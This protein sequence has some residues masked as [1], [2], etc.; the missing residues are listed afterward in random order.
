MTDQD[1]INEIQEN[2]AEWLEMSD[3]PSDHLARILAKRLVEQNKYIEHLEQRLEYV[4][5]SKIRVN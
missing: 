2:A 5:I 3:N 4:S 1:I